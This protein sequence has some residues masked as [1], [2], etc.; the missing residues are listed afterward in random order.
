MYKETKSQLAGLYISVFS[1]ANTCVSLRG[2]EGKGGVD[3][4]NV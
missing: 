3:G 4:Y 1:I 2:E